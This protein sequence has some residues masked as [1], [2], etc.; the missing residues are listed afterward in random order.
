MVALGD[1]VGRMACRLNVGT[2]VDLGSGKG[3]LSQA[4]TRFY[5][6]DV[7]AVDAKKGNSEGA[8]KRRREEEDEPN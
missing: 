6:M 7:M 2:L 1:V 8:E 5:G 4:M 3:Y